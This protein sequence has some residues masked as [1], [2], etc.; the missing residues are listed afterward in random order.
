MISL[1]TEFEMFLFLAMS[2]EF[3]VVWRRRKTFLDEEPNGGDRNRSLK[4]KSLTVP[5]NIESCHRR[6]NSQFKTRKFMSCNHATV[7]NGPS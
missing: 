6:K 5:Q 1:R 3:S 7:V 2:L 4:I